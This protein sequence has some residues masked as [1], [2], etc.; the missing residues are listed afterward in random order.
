MEIGAVWQTFRHAVDIAPQHWR[1]ISIGHR[2]VA[3]PN[4][5]D[6]GSD[7]IADRQLR[8]ANLLSNRRKPR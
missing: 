4:Q 2:G 5:L 7:L 1:Q 3:A 6:Q 8:E